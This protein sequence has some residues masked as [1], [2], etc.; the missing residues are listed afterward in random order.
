MQ[1]TK[2]LFSVLPKISSLQNDSVDNIS[3]KNRKKIFKNKHI[4][5][6]LPSSGKSHYIFKQ[7]YFSILTLNFSETLIKGFQEPQRE[8]HCRK[9]Q[10]FKCKKVMLFFVIFFIFLFRKLNKYGHK[11]STNP[12]LKKNLRRSSA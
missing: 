3:T 11:I 12:I 5:T 1:I 7:K 4:V 6:K 10:Y 2:I 9:F 8:I